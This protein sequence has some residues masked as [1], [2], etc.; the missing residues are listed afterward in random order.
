MVYLVVL[1]L[2]FAWTS[3]AFNP[4]RVELSHT[5]IVD[6][7]EQERVKAFVIQGSAMELTLHSAYEGKTT[8]LCTLGPFEIVVI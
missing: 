4:N 2:I 5:Q 3:G 8:I 7:F 1:V 6:L